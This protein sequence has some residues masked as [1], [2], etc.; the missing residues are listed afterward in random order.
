M[1]R[2][3]LKGMADA[4]IA[5][6]AC[7]QR[8]QSRRQCRS[9]WPVKGSAAAKGLL[10]WAKAAP[11]ADVG[12]VCG[13]GLGHRLAQDVRNL[14]QQPGARHIAQEADCCE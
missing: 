7:C 12:Q 5:R 8:C 10:R 11:A 14:L 13:A 1:S 6:V 3:L 4:E 9:C 2:T